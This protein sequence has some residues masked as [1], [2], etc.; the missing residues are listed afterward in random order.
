VCYHEV[1]FELN[2]YWRVFGWKK[3]TSVRS[4]ESQFIEQ[5]DVR[6][7]E[8][9]SDLPTDSNQV[10]LLFVADCSSR[11]DLTDVSVSTC[12]SQHRRFH[13]GESE[14]LENDRNSRKDDISMEI[15]K[16]QNI[17]HE[18]NW[19]LCKNH[20][21]LCF[22]NS[23]CTSR[24]NRL[25]C[26]LYDYI[27]IMNI[28]NLLATDCLKYRGQIHVLLSSRRS[29]LASMPLISINYLF[30]SLLPMQ[31]NSW[32]VSIPNMITASACPICTSISSGSLRWESFQIRQS[33]F[34]W[35]LWIIRMINK[36]PRFFWSP[37]RR[38]CSTAVLWIQ[39]S[40]TQSLTDSMISNRELSPFQR[41]SSTASFFRSTTWPLPKAE[42]PPNSQNRKA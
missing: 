17:L 31:V 37:I 36:S 7:R 27:F 30:D 35:I 16:S 5:G 29:L 39:F 4:D 6:A 32:Y 33:P 24:I 42:R 13:G 11:D 25:L 18:T 12:G 19:K 14:W 28:Q 20:Q 10:L 3:S 41:N 2:K 1:G 9:F 15:H 21:Y 38:T 22:L 23:W 26:L 40:L 8:I 34:W